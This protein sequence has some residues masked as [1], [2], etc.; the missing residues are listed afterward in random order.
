[1]IQKHVIA[2]FPCKLKSAQTS[3][4]LFYNKCVNIISSG[5]FE[6]ALRS[7]VS[8]QHCFPRET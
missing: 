8:C 3:T 7:L 6:G 5:T 2:R 1:M 4:I